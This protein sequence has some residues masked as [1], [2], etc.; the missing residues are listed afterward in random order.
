MAQ[1]QLFTDVLEDDCLEN[2]YICHDE[3]GDA[4]NCSNFLDVDWLSSSGNSIEEEIY[5][6]CLFEI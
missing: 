4:C 6:R 3:H 2:D 5:E 1:R